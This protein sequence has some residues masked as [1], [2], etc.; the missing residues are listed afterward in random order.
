MNIEKISS[1]A[2][3]ESYYSIDHPSGL[4]IYVMP[5]EGYSS[6]YAMFGTK[7]GSTDTGFRIAGEKDFTVIPEGTAHFLEHKLFESEEL[8]AFERYAETGAS[9]NAYTSFDQT[10]YLFSCSGDFDK[11]LEILLDFVQH[12]YFTKETVEK[13]QGIIGQE[14]RMY[15]DEPGW[16]VEFNCLRAMYKNHPVRVDIAGTEE[17]IA[18]ISA[19]TL[20]SCYEAFYDLSNMVLAVAGNVTAEQVLAV[21]D[22]LLGKSKHPAVEKM[23]HDEPAEI[24]SEYIEQKLAVTVP[25][26][27]LGCKENYPETVRPLRRRLE[28]SILL[29]IIAGKTS[30]LYRRLFDKGLIN[31]TFGA[32]YFAGDGYSAMLF[33][34]ESSDPRAVAGEIKAEIAAMK[35]NGINEEAFETVR[36]KLYGAEI[37]GYNDVDELA[38]GLVS[39]HFLGCGLF[40]TLGILSEVTVQDIEKLLAEA[41]DEKLFALSVVLP[42]E[43]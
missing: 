11:S 16:Q 27:M 9:A 22:R 14:I 24:A 32:E 39:A 6:A 4:K 37:M 8:G 10:C 42:R 5:K 28:M 38:S 21:A 40:D 23:P 26:F 19:D 12:P 31:S 17:S 29:S 34:G 35:K 33:S 1:A 36:R 15:Q 30:P 18:E 3:G 41:F 25:L 7:Y 43:Q 2:L 20:Y 13:E